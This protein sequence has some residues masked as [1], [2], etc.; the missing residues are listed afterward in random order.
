MLGYDASMAPASILP[1]TLRI[2][3]NP[4]A[5]RSG[6][7]RELTAAA[8]RLHDAGWTVE[9][10]TT[11]GPGSATE[12]AAEAAARGIEVVAASGGD[13]T[14]HE[15]ANGLACTE[16]ALAVIPSGT[17][18]IWAHEAFVPRDVVRAF[19]VIRAGRRARVDVGVVE[20]AFG[21]R[22][23]LMMC[24]IGLDAEVVRRV[25]PGS[26]GKRRFGKAWYALVGARALL[27]ARPTAVT[28]G[29]DGRELER[30]LLQAVAG[31]TRLYGGVMRLTSAARMD[32]GLLDVCVLSGDGRARQLGLLTGAM[33]GG[34]HRRARA[35][36]AD[37]IDYLRGDH[38]EV[39]SAD[40]LPVQ[41]DGEYLG[42]TPVTLSV[43][44]LAL[45]VLLDWRP[46]VLL[47][48]R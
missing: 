18:N 21:R 12:L 25:G 4:R 16:T 14:V 41:A 32:D 8:G 19:E 38:I 29:L 6:A 27:S 47:G 24:G 9:V 11:S 34:L 48:E 46:N 35:D 37:G 42:E 30:P 17:A 36:A 40:P 45:T 15:V 23:F 3:R 7:E 39:R 44:P 28:L 10:M 20:G 43:A 26:A 22:Y 2:I 1:H 31:N 5:R 13:G 33:R